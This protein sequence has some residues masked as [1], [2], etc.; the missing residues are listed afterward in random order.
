MSQPARH[1]HFA[2]GRAVEMA[3][4]DSEPVAAEWCHRL[5]A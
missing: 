4:R 5:S 2:R 3:L 1:H